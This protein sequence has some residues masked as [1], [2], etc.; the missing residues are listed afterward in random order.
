MSLTQVR[1]RLEIIEQAFTLNLM[2][3]Q[4]LGYSKPLNSQ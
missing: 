3:I 4:G 1:T 2:G